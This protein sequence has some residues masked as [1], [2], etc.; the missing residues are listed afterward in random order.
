MSSDPSQASTRDPL[1]RL[2]WHGGFASLGRRRGYFDRYALQELLAADEVRELVEQGLAESQPASERHPAVFPTLAGLREAA[3]RWPRKVDENERVKVV[4]GSRVWEQ[5]VEGRTALV[6]LFLS[7]ES[8]AGLV[9]GLASALGASPEPG[10]VHVHTVGGVIPP[11]LAATLDGTPV[12]AEV[13]L[14]LV[15][16]PAAASQLVA[17]L[18]R[19]RFLLD[20]RPAVGSVRV[21]QWVGNCGRYV[22]TLRLA[23][24]VAS[25]KAVATSPELL[26]LEGLVWRD[27]GAVDAGALA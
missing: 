6:G 3:R 11:G 4:L 12:T 20:V 9:A 18:R 2:V 13:G 23:T 25:L 7:V 8:V 22:D 24:L 19:Y 14:E 21:F 10:S 15:M 1:Y 27:D 16:V 26:Q 5:E 17:L